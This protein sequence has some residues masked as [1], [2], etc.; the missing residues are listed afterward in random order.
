MKVPDPSEKKRMIFLRSC[1]LHALKR[2]DEI[3]LTNGAEDFYYKRAR[4]N[5]KLILMGCKE[6]F[7]SCFCVSMGTN[8]AD[9]YDAYIKMDKESV[10]LE[11]KDEEL[12]TLLEGT[13]SEDASFEIDSPSR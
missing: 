3:Y 12:K 6:S 8:Q 10:Y 4:E 7:D 13:E 1:D 2:L 5:T 11:P 9:N